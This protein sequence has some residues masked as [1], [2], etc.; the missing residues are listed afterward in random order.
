M[1]INSLP[2][3]TSLADELDKAFPDRVHPDGTIGNEEHQQESSDHNPDDT[4]GVLTPFTD[5]DGIP[6]VHARDVSSQLNKPGW[7]QFRVCDIVRRRHAAGYDNRLQNI[8]CDGMIASRSWGWVWRDYGGT[9]QHFGHSHWSFRYGSGTAGNPENDTSPWGILAAVQAQEDDLTQAE[10]NALMDGWWLTRMDSAPATSPVNNSRNYLRR[11]PWN[12]VVVPATA[13]KPEVT[14][15]TVIMAIYA[16][17][18][19]DASELD[20]VRAS[21]QQ[22]QSQMNEL[23]ADPAETGFAHPIVAAAEYA[24][25][26][27][28]A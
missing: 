22:V 16:A 1:T 19:G 21:L 18:G 25:N 28:P 17:V 27:E 7:T 3:S 14:M 9:D 26:N 23:T 6:E 2:A 13:D 4:P 12:L 11:A 20:A 24:E 8:I 15:Y 5:P 10:F